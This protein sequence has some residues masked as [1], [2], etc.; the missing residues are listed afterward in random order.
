MEKGKLVMVRSPFWSNVMRNFAKGFMGRLGEEKGGMYPV[1]VTLWVT[2][3]ELEDADRAA[4]S[5]VREY[6][7]DPAV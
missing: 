6:L 1:T 2:R 3:E 5:V 7:G 4:D